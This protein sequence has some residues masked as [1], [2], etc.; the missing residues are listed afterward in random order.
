[1]RSV[2]PCKYTALHAPQPQSNSKGLI[3]TYHVPPMRTST[4]QQFQSHPPRRFN[5][6]PRPKHDQ[7]HGPSTRAPR[8]TLAPNTLPPLSRPNP[9]RR[10]V[11]KV[12]CVGAH[13]TVRWI[14]ERVRCR[15][16]ACQVILSCDRA[17]LA[18][19]GGFEGQAIKR[20]SVVLVFSGLGRLDLAS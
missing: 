11:G 15:Q 4:A 17:V 12:D 6:T 5:S 9:S 13:T 18:C 3:P 20:A 14:D 10:T 2:C 19:F 8:A 7:T 16:T 1:M